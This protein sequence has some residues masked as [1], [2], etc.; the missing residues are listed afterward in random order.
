MA[1]GEGILSLADLSKA[2]R[3]AATVFNCASTSSH[4]HI[5]GQG[6]DLGVH[7]SSPAVGSDPRSEP[8]SMTRWYAAP[9]QAHIRSPLV[10]AAPTSPIRRVGLRRPEPLFRS[11]GEASSHFGSATWI[12]QD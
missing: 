12:R 4:G 6:S 11:A 9:D 10:A 2:S 7:G 3:S 1:G 8:V 5:R